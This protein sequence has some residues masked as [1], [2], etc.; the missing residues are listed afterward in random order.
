MKNKDELRLVL[1]TFKLDSR[2]TMKENTKMNCYCSKQ[3][4]EELMKMLIEKET[5]I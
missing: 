4:S 2:W 5:K 3:V 1:G